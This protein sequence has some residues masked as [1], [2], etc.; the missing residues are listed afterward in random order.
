VSNYGANDVKEDF[1][2]AVLLFALTKGTPCEAAARATFPGRY[3]IL[4]RMFPNGYPAL[5]QRGVQG[6]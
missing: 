6:R 5:D 1:A 2:E 3:A 4:D